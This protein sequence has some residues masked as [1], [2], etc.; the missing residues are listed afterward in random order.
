MDFVLCIRCSQRAEI[1]CACR[2]DTNVFCRHH[3]EQ[4]LSSRD[5]H[6]AIGLNNMIMSELGRPNTVQLVEMTSDLVRYRE[7]LN[8]QLTKLNSLRSFLTS[9]I[10]TVV[11]SEVS[12]LTSTLR[13]VQSTLNSFLL[14]GP[15][16]TQV[17]TT[18]IHNYR[19]QSLR[20]VINSYVEVQPDKEHSIATKLSE[21]LTSRA[22]LPRDSQELVYQSSN[23]ASQPGASRIEPYSNYRN[24]L[25]NNPPRPDINIL[26]LTDLIGHNQAINA[27]AF[28]KDNC[29]IATAG[30]DCIIKIWSIYT[31][32]V[33]QTIPVNVGVVNSLAISTDNERL[34]IGGDDRTVRVWNMSNKNEEA[35]LF[36]HT[37]KVNAVLVSN[38]NRYIISAGAYPDCSVKIWNMRSKKLEKTL[39]G[40]TEE[41]CY[42]A[43]SFDNRYI[44]SASKPYDVTIKVWSVARG[45]QLG[46]LR[47]H[48]NTITSLACGKIRN[49]TV[50]GSV[51]GTL[52]LWNIE[53][54]SE[55]YNIRPEVGSI[56]SVSIFNLDT[57]IACAGRDEN[58]VIWS[59]ISNEQRF[60]L[61]WGLSRVSTMSISENNQ[62]MITGGMNEKVNLWSLRV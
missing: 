21:E 24:A 10:E 45:E 52:R 47:G 13:D 44:L 3:Y 59:L 53:N 2:T 40:H 31:S 33:K 19:Q 43:Q 39:N 26:K 38:D 62:F 36:G 8:F 25:A 4:H 34:I 15:D 51:D 37:A 5:D 50:S 7:S 17:L 22:Y 20:G 11:D 46:L 48:T 18:A 27:S 9:R 49:I 61:N 29:H 16:S 42:I 14:S 60:R 1:A 28:F 12:R 30:C 58:L 56:L 35:V 57:F 54:Y 6:L 32:S 41:V 55:L 23:F